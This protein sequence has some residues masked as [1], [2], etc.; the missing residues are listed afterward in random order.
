MATHYENTT[1]R[2]KL[3]CPRCEGQGETAPVKGRTLKC[4]RCSGTGEDLVGMLATWEADLSDLR[5]EWQ[6]Y[7][8]L[9]V[10]SR[11]GRRFGL[12]KKLNALTLRGKELASQIEALRSELTSHKV[13][14]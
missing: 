2:V 3:T 12:S 11:G 4:S 9:V 6:H 14:F 8:D 5:L 7:H 1:R 13:P 10:S